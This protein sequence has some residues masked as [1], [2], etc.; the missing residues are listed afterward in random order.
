MGP[1]KQIKRM[2]AQTRLIATIVVLVSVCIL[3]YALKCLNLKNDIHC[4]HACDE[5]A[6]NVDVVMYLE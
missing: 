5:V 1:V 6:E 3:V 4:K 2:F